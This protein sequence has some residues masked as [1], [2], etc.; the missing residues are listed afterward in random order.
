MRWFHKL[1]LR[2]RSLLRKPRVGQELSVRLRLDPIVPA[3]ASFDPGLPKAHRQF[4][5]AA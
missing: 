4:S 1:P 3:T 2:L 5:A